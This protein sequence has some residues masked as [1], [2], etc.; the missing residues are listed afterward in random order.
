MI[1]K[2][3]PEF[4]DLRKKRTERTLYTSHDIQNELLEL[5]A[6]GLFSAI[7]D[8]VSSATYCAV[9]ADETKDIS[10][11][12]QLS[13]SLRFF[14]KG[15]V[16]ERFIGFSHAVSVTAESIAKL[17]LERLE[18]MGVKRECLIA[19]CYDGANVMSG[20]NSGVQQRIRNDYPRAV[21][22]HC[23][24]HCLQLALVDSCKRI[25]TAG[26][27]LSTLARLYN[28]VT[29]SNTRFQLFQ[30]KSKAAEASS[31]RLVRHSDTRWSYYHRTIRAVKTNF[32]ALLA[33]LDEV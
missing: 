7:R 6:D 2:H 8:E 9:L 31:Y 28:F 15:R 24:N 11:A 32:N 26:E 14:C 30:Q 20:C 21:Y 1:E 3:S 13:V 4:A 27:F 16:I 12:E 29:N 17:V 18:F 23:A 10:K 22:V 33:T 25:T 19:Q 5:S